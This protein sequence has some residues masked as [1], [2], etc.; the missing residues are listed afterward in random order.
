LACII[1]S[2]Q[3]SFVYHI[4]EVLTSNISLELHS[5]YSLTFPGFVP[6]LSSSTYCEIYCWIHISIM[7]SF[8]YI[9]VSLILRPIWWGGKE[10]L[11]FLWF[12]SLTCRVLYGRPTSNLRISVRSEIR[13][14]TLKAWA[15]RSF[16]GCPSL[17]GRHSTAQEKRWVA[18]WNQCVF[19]LNFMLFTFYYS[20]YRV[21][22]TALV[23]SGLGL[24]KVLPD[25]S[26]FLIKMDF[27]PNEDCQSSALRF[28]WYG[29]PE[30]R[31]PG[32]LERQV[33]Q[34]DSPASPQ[35]LIEVVSS[36]ERD[37]T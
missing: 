12:R 2:H 33:A 28:A 21:R 3:R 4:F 9:Y 13:K 7:L 27:P 37:M 18:V 25:H 1:R 31:L 34:V 17:G 11:D 6:R 26:L 8:S 32:N 16:Y 22:G 19:I 10:M 23:L 14:H 20:V 24:C 29:W 35:C 36:P 30:G 15:A 5:H